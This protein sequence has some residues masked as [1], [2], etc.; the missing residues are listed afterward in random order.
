MFR[1]SLRALGVLRAPVLGI[2]VMLL[3]FLRME[4]Q[5][6]NN[7]FDSREL[8]KGGKRGCAQSLGGHGHRQH[9]Y[10]VAE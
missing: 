9:T 1:V 7:R 3:D 6:P 8:S 2:R 10:V 5:I 4:V